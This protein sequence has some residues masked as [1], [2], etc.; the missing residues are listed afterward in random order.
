MGNAIVNSRTCPKEATV[1]YV[2]CHG[3]L[4][5]FVMVDGVA[6]A[7][8][9]AGVDLGRLSRQLCD[10]RCATGGA[11]GLLVF[12]ETQEG[13]A[14]RMFNPDGSEAEMCGNGIRCVARLAAELLHAGEFTLF[15]GGR[16]Y[17]I[18][19]GEPIGE[20][21][22][23]FGV[24]IGIATSSPDFAFFG[25]DETFVGKVIA[26][27]DT[28]L[29]FTALSLGNPHVT[30][31]VESI[32]TE[33][34]CELGERVKHLPEL[35]PRGVNVSLYECTAEGLFVATYERGAGLTSSCGTA[36]TASATAAALLGLIPFGAE[37]DVRNSGG[38]VRC[39]PEHADDGALCTRLTGNA[40]YEF[41]GSFRTDAS[42][43]V[44]EVTVGERFDSETQA[45]GRFAESVKRNR[46]K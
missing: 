18:T 36:M 1:R 15:S 3:S 32:D 9:L 14:M 42:G 27:L 37:V 21:L 20:G 2:K 13:Y 26:P 11:D 23:T 16:P 7:G 38:M 12:A 44:S 43:S 8:S 19:R 33:L 4:N 22:A 46:K 40:T 28:R 31:C 24:G 41:A 35:F 6:E 34:L 39:L 17:R 10:A 30:A 5:R 45:Y 29:R 25:P